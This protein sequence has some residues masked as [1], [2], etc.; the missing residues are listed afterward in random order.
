MKR[1][2]VTRL[3]LV[4]RFFIIVAFIIAANTVFAGPYANEKLRKSALDFMVSA[5][6]EEELYAGVDISLDPSGAVKIMDKGN[7]FFQYLILTPRAAKATSPELTFDPDFKLPPTVQNV[8]IVVHGW[9]DK[10]DAHWPADIASAYTQITDPDKWICGYFDWKGGAAVANPV[11]SARY[12]SEIAG[13]RLAKVILSI[14]QIKE[15][16]HVH[17]IAHSAG[18]WAVTT[19]ANIIAEKTN[20][21]IHLTLLDAYVPPLWKEQDLGLV[22]LPRKKSIYVE[23]YYTKDITFDSTEKDLAAAHNVDLTDIDIG[24]KTHEFP[25]QWYYATVAGK[26]RKKDKFNSRKIATELNGINY[27]FKRGLEAGSDNF[28][29]SCT[30]EKANKAPKIPKPKEKHWFDISSWFQ[31]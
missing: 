10:G 19:A 15:L 27:G 12:S 8:V 6:M 29:K 21:T 3:L 9:L 20:A 14:P 31:K 5:G 13:P 23:H 30:L 7:F 24:M 28:K 4:K 16:K 18:T 22:S 17:L 26:Y 11:D 2:F 1:Y 25:Y